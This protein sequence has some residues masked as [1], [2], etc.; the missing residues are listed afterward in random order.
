MSTN[1]KIKTLLEILWSM[2]QQEEAMVVTTVDVEAGT[3]TSPITNVSTSTVAMN[4]VAMSSMVMITVEATIH[5]AMEVVMV[6]VAKGTATIAV[7]R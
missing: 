1:L 7:W 5:V 4:N 2:R 6:G 3:E